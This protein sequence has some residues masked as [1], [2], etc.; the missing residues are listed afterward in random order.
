MRAFITNLGNLLQL[1]STYPE[2]QNFK[3]DKKQL[4]IPMYQ[5]EYKW[6]NDRIDT[7]IEDCLLYTSDAADEL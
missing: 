4:V 6:T 7:L 5:R 3:G 2:P 1:D